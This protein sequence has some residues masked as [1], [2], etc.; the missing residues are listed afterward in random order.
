MQ[1]KVGFVGL[2]MMGLPMVENLS[3]SGDLAVAAHDSDPAARTRLQALPAWGG[4]LSW[5]PSLAALADCDVVITMLPNSTAT[6]SVVDPALLDSLRPGAV[7]VDMGSS[8]PLSTQ[9][10][11]DRAAE[12]GLGFV[13]AP[14]SGSVA[15][16]RTGTLSIM[17]GGSEHAVA[18][19]RPVM[20]RM[21]STLIHTGAVGS[22]HA[23]KA[24]N[25]Y[26][27]AA[28][29][30]A[31]SEAVTIARR[32]ELDLEVFAQVLNASSGRNVAT[33]TKLA[34]FVIPRSFAGGFQLHLQAKDLATASDL[35]ERTGVAAPQLAL[36]ADFWRQA[37]S[38]LPR[39]T[40]NTE[41]LKVVEGRSTPSSS[42]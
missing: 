23:M 36:C 4:A 29:L 20:E 18:R 19:V 13:D 33:E 34:Q 38:E 15:K 5:A 10:L 26:V 12:R 25:N 6:E 40:D 30:L 22:A 9:G 3:R 17:L 39:G 35:R 11:A 2:G 31:M 37:A 42:K 24:L 1:F 14:V 27:Y 28:G 21:G 8:H 41:I 7:I 32:M 16:A